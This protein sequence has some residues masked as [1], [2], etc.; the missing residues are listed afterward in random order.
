MTRLGCVW[1]PH[2]IAQAMG[3]T[4]DARPLLVVEGAQVLD[5]SPDAA[6]L[7]VQ[8]G[9]RISKALA[10]CPDARVVPLDRARCQALWERVLDAL[11]L[12]SPAVE[13]ARWGLAYL[14]ASGMAGL[15]GSEEA[16]CQ[17]VRQEVE[18]ASQMPARIGVAGSRFAAWL[19]AKTAESGVGVVEQADR[20]FLSPFPVAEL[21][22]AEDTVRRLH[23]LGIRTIG[24]F[25]RLPATSVA[26]QFG[27]DA[28]EAHQWARG[29]DNRPLSGQRREVVEVNL[30]FDIPET[31]REP[32][33]Q[34]LLAASQKALARL[35]KSGL[36]VRRVTLQARLDKGETWE[37]T[38]WVGEAV[39][40]SKLHS[41]LQGLL[42]GLGG[43]GDG[44]A[45]VSLKFAGLEP[46]VGRQLN[47]FAHAEGRTRLEETLRKLAQKHSPGCVVRACVR[48]PGALLLR[49]RYALEEVDP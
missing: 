14:D 8:V 43:D 38:A 19:A 26:E 46:T 18:H 37:R 17:A 10:R 42:A 35:G 15:Y 1:I 48:S 47:L 44:I 41:L 5:A 21:P 13:E 33:A 31:G 39:G 4:G 34:A 40:P 22:L 7:G 30:D 11:A 49:D 20:A 28:L 27:P 3:E 36:A 25:A 12:H 29:M 2:F 9:E 24:A 45:S 23:L 6:A 32:L 16:W